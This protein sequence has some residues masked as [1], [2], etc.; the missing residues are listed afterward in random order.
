M[1]A[2]AARPLP[3]ALLRAAAA[4]GTR[5]AACPWAAGRPSCPPARSS[6]ASPC[7]RPAAQPGRP[8][9]LLAPAAHHA[10]R[11]TRP[12]PRGRAV[13][14]CTA[15][16]L[17]LQRFHVGA[18]RGGAG[19]PDAYGGLHTGARPLLPSSRY[20]RALGRPLCLK[21][22]S[23]DGGLQPAQHSVTNSSRS[24][25]LAA[26]SSVPRPSQRPSLPPPCRAPTSCWRPPADWRTL[27]APDEL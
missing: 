2:A 22:T 15:P 18:R 23:G 5:L 4:T 13:S 19:G 26:L 1:C 20:I 12:R 9:S 21:L 24:L 16:F 14:P 10:R 27:N 6:P 25:S 17:P 11:L 3:P 8:P 7:R